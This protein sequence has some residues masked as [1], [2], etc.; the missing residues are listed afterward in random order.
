M[1]R[2][3]EWRKVLQAELRRW[4]SMSCDEVRAELRTRAAYELV[5]DSKQY[6]VEVELL[7]ETPGY[8][9]ISVAVDDSSLPAS[10]HPESDSF[11]CP[12]VEPRS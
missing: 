2:R 7:E 6:Q 11:V 9:H 12:K 4:S 1:N 8:L 10:I 3:E 5:A